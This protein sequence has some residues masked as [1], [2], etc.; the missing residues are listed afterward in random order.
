MS[1]QCE[2]AICDGPQCTAKRTAAYYV[3]TGL[4]FARFICHKKNDD[5]DDNDILRCFFFTGEFHR[6]IGLPTLFG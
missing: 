6:C 1:S 5:D 2:D 4:I 3:D